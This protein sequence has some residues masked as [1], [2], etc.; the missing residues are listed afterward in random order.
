MPSEDAKRIR[1]L[2]DV[3]SCK[4]CC[5]GGNNK[6][7][8]KVLMESQI[9]GSFFLLVCIEGSGIK[10]LFRCKQFGV[11]HASLISALMAS[12]ISSCRGLFI[13]R[14]QGIPPIMKEECYDV[15]LYEWTKV[16]HTNAVS[17]S[18]R[19]RLDFQC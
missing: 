12:L 13:F 17:L 5:I 3:S 9:A 4:L 16:D 19:P 2:H 8:I 6:R 7:S 11:I 10:C 14:G 15:D 1:I 18:P